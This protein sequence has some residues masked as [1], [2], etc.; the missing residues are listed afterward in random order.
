M[1][2]EQRQQVLNSP[3]FKN[4]FTNHEREMLNGSL[5]LPLA[6]TNAGSEEQK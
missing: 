6:P 5:K 4:M 3:R 2:P 1:P